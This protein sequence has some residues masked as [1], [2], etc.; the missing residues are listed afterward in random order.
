[1]ARFGLMI[2]ACLL[3]VALL[4][5]SAVAAER[6]GGIVPGLASCCLIGIPGGQIQNSG[7]QVPSRS[8]A[9]ILIIPAIID[10]V[11]AYE[12]ETAEQYMGVSTLPTATAG[13]GGFGPAVMSACCWTG[14]PAGHMMNSGMEVPTR[15]WLKLVPYVGVAVSL[16]D[17]YKA[18]QG[19]TI[20]GYA[21]SEI[22]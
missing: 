21:Y 10:G 3:V 9:R 13:K 17:G 15:T 4:S 20:S 2:L 5:G 19:E 16:Y 22:K 12:G 18:Y 7:G 6:K 14:I 11:K 1:M 8:W